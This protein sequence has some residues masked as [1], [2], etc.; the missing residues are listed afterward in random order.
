M[1]YDG[2]PAPPP[3]SKWDAETRALVTNAGL[4]HDPDKRVMH[5][6]RSNGQSAF[7]IPDLTFL[8]ARVAVFLDGC[9]WHGCPDHHPEHAKPYDLVIKAN[10]EGRGWHVLRIW[11]HTGPREAADIIREAVA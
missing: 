5:G 8:D 10:L 7:C 2:R 9:Y 6:R 3:S 11:E 1:T 4:T